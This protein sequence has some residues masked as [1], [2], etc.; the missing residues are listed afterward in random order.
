MI[1]LE[2]L[3]EIFT[4]NF[5]KNYFGDFSGNVFVFVFSW[6]NPL[7]ILFVICLK[8]LSAIALEVYFAIPSV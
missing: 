2:I 3:L 6:A 5:T 1:R 7:G 4:G 8:T